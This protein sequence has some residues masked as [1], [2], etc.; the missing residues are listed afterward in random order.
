MYK[1]IQCMKSQ[2]LS[3][4]S[5]RK[6]PIKFCQISPQSI[7]IYH[8]LKLSSQITDIKY[9]KYFFLHTFIFIFYFS[10][11][12]PTLKSGLTSLLY[13]MTTSVNKMNFVEAKVRAKI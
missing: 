6:L 13:K 2:D 8:F 3:I 10:L 1:C 12:L 5:T 11:K 7:A 4:T 9:L